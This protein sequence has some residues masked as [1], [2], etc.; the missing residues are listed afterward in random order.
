MMGDYMGALW[1]GIAR[2]GTFFHRHPAESRVLLSL[3]V[4]QNT[5][6]YR[7]TLK[8]II[9]YVV[10]QYPIICHNWIHVSSKGN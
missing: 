5:R 6:V 4:W 2:W 8:Y 1:D 3:P 10:I 7:D 9:V